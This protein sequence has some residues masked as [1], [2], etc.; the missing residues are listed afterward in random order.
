MRLLVLFTFALVLTCQNNDNQPDPNFH[1]YLCIGQSNMEGTAKIEAQDL[2]ANDRF[3]SLQVVDCPEDQKYAGNWYTAVPPYNHCT[4]GLSLADSFGKKMIAS[5]PQN[6]KVGIVSMAVGG[7][8]IRLFDKD[9][10][11][12]HLATYTQDWFVNK[13][14][15]YDYNP[16]Q[17]LINM[18]QTAQKSGVIKGILIH[19]GETNTGDENWPNYVKKVYTDLIKDLNLP[20]QTPLLIGE[21]VHQEQNGVCASMNAIIAKTPKVISSAHVIS[22]KGCEA[23][24]DNVHFNATGTRELGIRYATKMIELLNK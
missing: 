3:L 6:N 10:Y 7:C 16:Y 2:V 14:K 8:D 9:L 15:A 19:Q 20:K 4:A 13:V 5:L 18:A 24:K 12:Q 17:L 23:Q 11:K 1:I 22:S 21:L